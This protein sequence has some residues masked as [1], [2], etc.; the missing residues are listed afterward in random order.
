[1]GKE[2]AGLLGE[3]LAARG[4]LLKSL[5]G[6]REDTA[7]TRPEPNEWSTVEVLQHVADVDSLQLRRFDEVRQGKPDLSKYDGAEWEG[8]RAAAERDGLSGVFLRLAAAHLGVLQAVSQLT[9]ADL[10]KSSRHARYGSM[11]GRQLV[12]M[13]IRHDRDHAQQI[14]KTRAAVEA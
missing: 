9:S 2:N 4:E 10:E 6:L 14:A 3:L 12:E 13:L 7:R 1:M 11:T 5:Q 8:E